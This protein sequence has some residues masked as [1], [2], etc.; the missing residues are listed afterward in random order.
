MKKKEI[1]IKYFGTPEFGPIVPSMFISTNLNLHITM[2]LQTDIL[3]YI[4][5]A[6]SL[7]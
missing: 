2:M 1:P 6:D 3:A 5:T 7:R 4:S